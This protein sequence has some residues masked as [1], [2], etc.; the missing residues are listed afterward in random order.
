MMDLTAVS[1]GNTVYVIL[2]NGDGTFQKDKRYDIAE[3][4]TVGD[5]NNDKKLD[6]AVTNNYDTSISILFG[7]GNGT[8]HNHIKSTTGSPPYS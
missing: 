3:S 8:F 2:G 6:I 1:D 7:N 5:F 4:V